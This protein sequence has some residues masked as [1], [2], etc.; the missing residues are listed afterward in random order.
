MQV[1]N[2]YGPRPIPGVAVEARVE[3]DGRDTPF[4]GVTDDRGEVEL[5]F[6]LPSGREDYMVKASAT[7]S[8]RGVERRVM[9]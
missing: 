5:V 2:P 6:E 7:A 3:L 8:Y 4:A 1:Y 9:T